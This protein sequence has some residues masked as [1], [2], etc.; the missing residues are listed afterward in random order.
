MFTCTQAFVVIW[1][2]MYLYILN[3]FDAVCVMIS[4]SEGDLYTIIAHTAW[5]SCIYK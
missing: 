1:D 5:F 2:E 4:Y 3:I